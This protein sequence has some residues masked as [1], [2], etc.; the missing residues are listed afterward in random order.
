M[1]NPPLKSYRAT[2]I[3]DTRG[4]DQP[5]ETLIEKLKQ[6]IGSLSAQVTDVQNLGRKDFIRVADKRHTGDHYVQ[7]TVQ[8]PASFNASLKTHLRLDKTVKRVMVES[9]AS[10]A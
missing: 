7:F 5:V 4:Y 2:F 10:M 9:V 3:L 1:S 8:A 6:S